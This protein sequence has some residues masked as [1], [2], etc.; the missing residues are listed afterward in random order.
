M[1]TWQQRPALP[2]GLFH[3]KSCFRLKRRPDIGIRCR[4]PEVDGG[5]LRGPKGSGPPLSSPN[6]PPSPHRRP[7]AASLSFTASPVPTLF[8]FCCPIFLFFS[9]RSNVA[10]RSRLTANEIRPLFL[11]PGSYFRSPCRQLRF[12]LPDLFPCELTSFVIFPAL[13]PKG[14]RGVRVSHAVI[15][16]AFERGC[17]P[18]SGIDKSRHVSEDMSA[19][20]A[21]P[22]SV[23]YGPRKIIDIDAIC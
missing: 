3:P 11:R 20:V 14:R 17:P 16:F 5:H 10:A 19:R 13:T 8:T 1:C 6:P 18:L 4:W 15:V 2:Y 7:L 12:C 9:F 23:S 21:Y 22:F